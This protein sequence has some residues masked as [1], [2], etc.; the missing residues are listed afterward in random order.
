MGSSDQGQIRSVL[1]LIRELSGQPTRSDSAAELFS[2]SFTV[3][4]RLVP[5]DIAAAVMLESNLD[6]HIMMR[7]GL[8]SLINDRFIE[9]VREQL[10]DVIPAS[11][12]AA[13]V[14]VRGES[15]ELPACEV[16]GN[17]LEHAAHVVVRAANRSAGLLL[18]FRSEPFSDEDR[19]ITEI[20]AATLSIVLAHMTAQERILNLA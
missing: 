2:Q 16:T 13:D 6:L 11:F 17:C 7:A 12:T 3:L 9:K 15:S 10:H 14:I 5:F 18:F 1:A 19:D 4:H 20:F 8:E